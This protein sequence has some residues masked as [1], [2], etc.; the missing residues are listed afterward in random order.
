MN[1]SPPPHGDGSHKRI[2][3]TTYAAMLALAT[4]IAQPAMANEADKVPQGQ[5][6]SDRPNILVIFGDDVGITNV[7]AYG[8]GVMGYRT[9]GIDRLAREGALFTDQYAQP[10]S[11]AGRAAFITGQYPIRTG[12]T[13]VGMVGGPVGMKA[14]DVT[15]AEV[16]KTRG[17]MTA[18]FGKNHLGDRNEHLPTVHGFDEFFGNLYHLNTEEEPEDPDYPKDPSFKARFGPRG[19]LKCRALNADNP[20]V[21]SD[22]RFGPWG[23][24]ACEDT[25]PLTIKRMETVD[26]EFID[27]TINFMQRAKFAKRPFFAWL[28]TTRMHVF[29]HVPKQYQQ[30]VG[31]LTSFNDRHGAGMLQHDEEIAA[32]LVKLDQMGL[33]RNTIVIYTA[34]NGAEHSSYPDGGTTP[35]RSDKMTTW[36]GGVRVPMLLRWPGHVPAG[37]ERNGIQS[38]MDLF[39]TL[40]SAAG[41]P[42]IV[43]RL[44]K[45]DALGSSTVKRGYIDGVNNLDYW[46]GKA[47]E[48]ARDEFIYY[49]EANL[50]AIR[51]NNWKAHFAVRDGYYGSTTKLELPWLYNLRQDPF[52]SYPQKPG[53]VENVLQ[54]KTYLF[55]FYMERLGRHFQTLRQYPPSQK[56]TTLSIDKLIGELTS[57]GP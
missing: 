28:N 24:Q 10:S 34:D 50:Q 19:V 8:H 14:Q 32:L 35:F 1:R 17:Y 16:L 56:A 3:R 5:T 41:V 18:Q 33:T 38:H 46:T 22:T 27:A 11:T 13:T 31:P 36:E 37:S 12:L 20:A 48:S 54:H 57:K 45:G 6:D 25:G 55:N 9:P 53:T 42:D 52:E 26:G 40:A 4:V 51:V 23:R 44:A 30:R 43:Q 15:L 7:S 29:H 21:P 2:R 47:S 39:T 49:S